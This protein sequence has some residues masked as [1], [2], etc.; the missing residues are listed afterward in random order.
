MRIIKAAALHRYRFDH[1]Q[2]NL[3]DKIF[4]NP[5]YENFTF[6]RRMFYEDF[7]NIF[8]SA[9]R[10][11]EELFKIYSNDD[12]L[13]KRLLLN[14][15]E[16][17]SSH[18]IDNILC[19]LV[20]EIAQS[21]ILFG[22]TYYFLYESPERKE[23]HITW[24]NANGISRFFKIYIQWIPKRYKENFN[25]DGVEFPREIRILDRAKLMRFDLPK[26]IKKM[27]SA[28]NRTLAV[29]DKHQHDGTGFF[30]EA[31]YENPNPMNYFD[32]RVWRDTQE[33][34]KFRTTRETGWDGRNNDS[35]KCSDFFI[36]Q[37]LLRFRRNQLIFRDHILCQLSDELTKVGRQYNAEF[38][39]VI[40]PTK[41][42]PKLDKI[43]ELE[44]RLS[45]EEVSFTEVLDFCYERRM[46]EA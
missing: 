27:L 16:R 46:G 40:S 30:T 33:Q 39:V 31:T 35:S 20:E 2:L 4:I 22:T 28:Q 29:L 38:H 41:S 37:R 21:L 23:N 19:N 36:C 6:N 7:A 25:S 18:S 24:L 8:H 12:E 14:I 44:A 43:N 26:A 45:R 15:Q 1:K 32:F 42:L 10:R 5:K 11:K 13:T 17:Y 3:I 9:S 34:V